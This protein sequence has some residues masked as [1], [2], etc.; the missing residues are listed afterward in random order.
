VPEWIFLEL[1]L[2]KI[3]AVLVTVNTAYRV[4]ELEYLLRQ[5]DITSLFMIEELRDNSYLDSV[6]AIIPE[7]RAIID[8][9]RETLRSPTFPR[10]KRVVVLGGTSRPG[11]WLYRQIEE[12]GRT[13]LEETLAARQRSIAPDDAAQI[14]Y[15][16]GTTG[17][18]SVSAIG[19]LKA[20]RVQY[21]YMI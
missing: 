2:A 13:V 21:F 9:T 4:A 6:Y 10:L 15:T 14:Q 20:E 7:M 11:C 16:S 3:G 12:L 5:G 1:A 19:K 18:Y 17:R 8:P